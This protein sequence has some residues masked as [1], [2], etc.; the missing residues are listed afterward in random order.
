MLS[1]QSHFFNSEYPDKFM[2]PAGPDHAQIAATNGILDYFDQIHS[3]HFP[4]EKSLSKRSKK[5]T[6]LFRETESINLKPLL[7]YLSDRNDVRLIGPSDNI[8]RAPTVAFISNNKSPKEIVQ[9][10][11]E[12]NIMAGAG[13]F[14]AYRPIKALGL[15]PDIGVVRLSFVHYNTKNEIISLINA[16]EK[17]L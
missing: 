16:L 2:V 12:N 14:Y 7:N 1:N 4:D 17:T 3:H 15:N 11:A 13:D 10:L 8:I 9:S 5:I 6:A